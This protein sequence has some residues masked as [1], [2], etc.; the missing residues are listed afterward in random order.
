M[1]T[2]QL[3][4]L[5]VKF[6]NTATD[7]YKKL[8]EIDSDIAQEFLD[9]SAKLYSHVW[10]TSY[11][12]SP[13]QYFYEIASAYKVAQKTLQLLKTFRSF[14][15]LD[16]QLLER[17]INQCN[18]LIQKLSLYTSSTHINFRRKI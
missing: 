1:Q 16:E 6:N 11:S 17:A 2:Q 15:Q 18:E 14:T 3:I 12:Q 4:D 9:L 5:A 10:Q 8:S 7:L 13:Q